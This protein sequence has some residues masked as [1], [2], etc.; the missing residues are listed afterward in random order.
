MRVPLLIITRGLPGSGKTTWAREY[1]AMA[2][3][4]TFRVNRD[5]LRRM[6]G[7]GTGDDE[8]AVTEIQYAAITTFLAGVRRADVVVDDTNLHDEHVDTLRRMAGRCGARFRVQ[9]FRMVPVETCLKRNR[10]PDRRA[11]GA[12]VPDHVI[13][14]MA[15][16]YGLPLAGLD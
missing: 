7:F 5:D 1:I 14:G 8:N 3:D 16:R 10:L 9:D 2:S 11:I 4:P 6:F 15:Q 12:V 13:V